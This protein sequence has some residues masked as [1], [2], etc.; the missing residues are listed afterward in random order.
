MYWI[1]VHKLIKWEIAKVAIQSTPF[2]I[3][4]NP[5]LRSVTG[6]AAP[7]KILTEDSAK[8]AWS[9]MFATIKLKSMMVT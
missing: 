1:V 6:W 2:A 9:I 8:N 3:T 5:S 7:D 4:T